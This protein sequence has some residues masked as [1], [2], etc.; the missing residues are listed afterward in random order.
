LNWIIVIFGFEEL[1]KCENVY[2][3]F[4]WEMQIWPPQWCLRFV[5][6]YGDRISYAGECILLNW[7]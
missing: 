7:L 1:Y 6:L 2:V 4:E 5:F 3:Q